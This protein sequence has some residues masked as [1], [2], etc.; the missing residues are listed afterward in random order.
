MKSFTTQVVLSLP[1]IGGFHE[2]NTEKKVFR[3]GAHLTPCIDK[4]LWIMKNDD[5]VVSSSGAVLDPFR[6]ASA[7][8]FV[9]SAP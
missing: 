1:V 2:L 6:W 8:L 4:S 3:N 7:P 9:V 5:R